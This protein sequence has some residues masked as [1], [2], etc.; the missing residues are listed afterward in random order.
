MFPLQWKHEQLLSCSSAKDQ[1]GDSAG[2]T[3]SGRKRKIIR[4]N[5]YHG[6]EVIGTETEEDKSKYS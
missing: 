3:E 5:D 1:R 2:V 4:E 6:A